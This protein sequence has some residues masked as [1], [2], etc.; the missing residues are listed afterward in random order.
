MALD[1][2]AIGK[3]AAAILRDANPTVMAKFV[4]ARVHE[5]LY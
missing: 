4:F 1:A 5:A 2:H 3:A